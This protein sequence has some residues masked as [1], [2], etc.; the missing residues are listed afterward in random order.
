MEHG[1]QEVGYYPRLQIHQHRT[2]GKDTTHGGAGLKHDTH[3]KRDNFSGVLFA[4]L[5]RGATSALPGGREPM[6]CGGR[7]GYT[8]ES[9]QSAVVPI[10]VL[11]VCICV[12]V[13]IGC[14]MCKCLLDG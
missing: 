11:F 8:M 5:P 9:L 4:P 13:W 1:E 12:F 14:T 6:T 7:N 3:G 10:A 2:L